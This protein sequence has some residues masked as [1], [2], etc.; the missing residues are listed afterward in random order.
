MK[1]ILSLLLLLATLIPCA[2]MFAVPSSAAVVSSDARLPFEDVSDTQWYYQYAAFA[3]MNE[4]I[5]G[6]GNDYTF[7]P[8]VNL[9][10]ATFVVMLARSFRLTRFEFSGKYMGYDSYD[11]YITSNYGNLGIFKDCPEGTWYTAYVEWAYSL[12]LVTGTGNDCF[13]PN[14]VMTREEAAV[15][16][17]RV[18]QYLGKTETINNDFDYFNDIN[19][20][21][22]WAKSGV[23]FV[24]NTGIMGSTSTGKYVFSPK[25]TMTRAQMATMF[26][27]FL[28]NPTYTECQHRTRTELSCTKGDW[29][30]GCGLKFTLPK[31]HL[32]NQ[33]SCVVGGKCKTCGEWIERDKNI[34]NYTAV[35]CTEDS[36][37]VD[38][39][40]VRQVAPGHNYTAV[41]CTK[42]SYCTRCGDVRS[43][44]LGHTTNLG[45]CSR[46]NIEI[47]PNEYMRV[48]YYMVEKGQGNGNGVYTIT[49][50]GRGSGY[51]YNTKITYDANNASFVLY[52]KYIAS[53]G[54]MEFTVTVPKQATSYKCDFKYKDY[55]GFTIA[56]GSGNVATSNSIYTFNISSS[57][58]LS[59]SDIRTHVNK[60]FGYALT[61][62]STE[63]NRIC[64]A[65]LSAF[66]F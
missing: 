7:A 41:S 4:I 40:K 44:A 57:G 30:R 62:L 37:C 50:N 11:A 33:L 56:S 45:I 53:S 6:Q 58:V 28:T 59:T 14:K 66:G 47:F 55:T 19:K 32:L 18:L 42:D 64:G 8:N 54:N 15:L 52:Y 12:G 3:Y 23:K 20:V 27:K 29:C 25:V 24:I 61:G 36:V 34:H 63:L 10:R 39:G 16:F 31:G 9:T 13:S 35:S 17:Y 46:C 2:T 48:G 51:T 43:P 26:Y 1:R 65:D 38:C 21:S 5:K 22:S 49:Y 60:G